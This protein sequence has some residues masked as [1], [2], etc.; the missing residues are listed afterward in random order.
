M[1]RWPKCLSEARNILITSIY[2]LFLLHVDHKKL[3]KIR[4]LTYC[5]TPSKDIAHIEHGSAVTA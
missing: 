4:L 5:T 2:V 3:F 1:V